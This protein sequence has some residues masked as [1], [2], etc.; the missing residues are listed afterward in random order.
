M[1]LCSFVLGLSGVNGLAEDLSFA[2]LAAADSKAEEGSSI[3]VTMVAQRGPAERAGV[4][5]GDLLLKVGETSVTTREELSAALQQLPAGSETQLTLFRNG[6]T[7]TLTLQLAG[8]NNEQPSFQA[9]RKHPDTSVLEEQLNL[10]KSFI[11]LLAADTLDH[12]SIAK[13]FSRLQ[14]MDADTG[15]SDFISFSRSDDEGGFI[16]RGN[17]YT[18]MLCATFYEKGRPD[19][20]YRLQ[21]LG[22]EKKLPQEL[23]QRLQKIIQH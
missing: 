5:P 4:R 14:A 1:L 12:A 10:Q 15:K 18:I 21:G 13:L 11:A 8:R 19:E 2:G 3:I 7:I 9:S 23:R 22:A 16:I 6:H 17:A 20:L